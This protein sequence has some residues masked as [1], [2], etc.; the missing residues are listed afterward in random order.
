VVGHSCCR[1]CCSSATTTNLAT[2]T[3]HG[4]GLGLLPGALETLVSVMPPALGAPG[5]SNGRPPPLP[6]PQLRV[7][8]TTTW[9]ARLGAP[10]MVAGWVGMAGWEP[11]PAGNE[12]ESCSWCC[13]RC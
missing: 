1:R 11:G 9:K 7:A 12:G 8:A 5:S 3:P 4:L 10:V 6:I 13:V 2:T